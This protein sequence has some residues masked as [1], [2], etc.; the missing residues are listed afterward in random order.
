[1]QRTL[2]MSVLSLAIVLCVGLGT[3]WPYF[4]SPGLPAETDAELHIYRTAEL[5]Y[6]LEAGNPYPRWAPDFFHGYGYPIFNYYAPLTYHLGHSLTM[7]HPE[8]AAEGARLV[9]ILALVVGALGAYEL[10]TL[11]GGRGGGLLGSLV[12]SCAPYILLINPHLRGDLAESLALGFVPW[13]LWAWELVWRRGG[14]PR[15][16]AA[17]VA[18][19]AV[20]LSHNLTGLTILALIAGLSLWRWLL[21]AEGARV[22][23]AVMTALIFVL[24]TSFFWLPFL[25]E[26]R[27][28]QLDVAGDGHYDF[29]NHFV[30]PQ[31]LFSLVL[32]L[33]GRASTPDVRMTTGLVPVV[34]ALGGTLYAIVQRRFRHI[35][36]YVLSGGLLLWLILPGGRPLW[37]LVPALSYYQFPWRFLGPVAALVV[38][39]VAGLGVLPR[40]G[41]DT[42]RRYT[43]LAPALLGMLAAGILVSALPGMSAM[44]W[45]PGLGFI[46]REDIIAAELDGRWRGTTSTND[47]VPTSVEMIPGPQE[48]VIAS[49]RQPPVDRVNRHTLPDGAVVTVVPDLPWVN[50][51]SVAAAEAFHLRLYLFD[52]PGWQAYVDGAP[53]AIEIAHPEGFITVAVPEG[54]HEVVVRFESTPVRDLSWILSGLGVAVLVA[55]TAYLTLRGRRLASDPAGSGRQLPDALRPQL[56]SARHAGRTVAAI[57]GVVI[58]IGLLKAVVFDPHAWF[59]ATSPLEGSL[60]ADYQQKAGFGGEISLLAYDVSSETVSPGDTLEITLYWIADHPITATYQSFVHLVYPEGQIRSQSDHLNPGGF[61]TNLWPTDHYI[62]DRHRL[63]VPVD[64]SPGSYLVSV[65]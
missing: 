62:V 31:D 42:L 12:F 64:A 45:E 44:S 58:V 21:L 28:V 57:G 38:P 34:L 22:P 40:R 16:L 50:R 59:D 49:F 3:A 37:E 25:A 30:L 24:L 46:S 48:S 15:I 1:M 8:R 10:G 35:G 9:F 52:F 29:R 27:Y 36:F 41:K 32:P 65:G 39:P 61:P 56:V 51:F 47:F 26:R 17:V 7:G 53:V 60:A 63:W 11:F 19:S 18:T 55:T 43:A 33:D 14:A 13:A 6:S 5:G 20:F 23:Q 4:Q 2:P 54:L